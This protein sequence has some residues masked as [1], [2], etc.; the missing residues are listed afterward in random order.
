V[1]TPLTTGGWGEP[2]YWGRQGVAITDEYIGIPL[3]LRG[4]VPT[5]PPP[6]STPMPSTAI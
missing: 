1:P 3:L 4:H 5:L 2:K 6:K